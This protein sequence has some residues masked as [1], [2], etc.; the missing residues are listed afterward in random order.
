MRRE[1]LDL[2]YG[3]FLSI[4]VFFSIS[5]FTV[6]FQINSPINRFKDVYELKIGFPFTYYHQFMV[7]CPIPSS[8]WNLSHLFWNCLIYWIVVTGVFLLIKRID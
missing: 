7:D 2:V 3:T 8:G 4:L 6:L 1:I 5:F